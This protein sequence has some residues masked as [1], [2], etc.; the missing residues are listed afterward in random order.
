MEVRLPKWGLGDMLCA[1]AAARALARLHPGLRVHFNRIPKVVKAF[2]DNLITP[3]LGL[4]LDIG[5]PDPPFFFWEQ[6]QW[7]SSNY[8]DNYFL[9]LGINFESPP[10]LELPKLP[11]F[12]AL[13]GVK[14]I[15]LQPRAAGKWAYPHLSVNILQRVIS[16]CPLPVVVT[17]CPGSGMGLRGI[18]CSYL[19]DEI[20]MLRLIQHAT[21]VL[22]PRSAGAHV[23]AGYGVPSIIWLPDDQLNWHLDYPAWKVRKIPAISADVDVQIQ[24]A[25]YDM[26]MLTSPAIP[27]K[28]NPLITQSLFW[29]WSVKKNMSGV[30]RNLLRLLIRFSPKGV[31]KLLKKTFIYS[32][33]R[34]VI[35]AE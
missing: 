9:S 13:R 8:V 31:R 24:K 27:T 2:G 14:Y 32:L 19:G 17:G 12:E 5:H 20:N 30:V 16:F 6:G 15:V 33:V 21:L 22:A 1:L 29:I 23:A 28:Y 4:S 26:L 18:D 11:P 34:K 3:G 35:P 25:L 10:R 7:S